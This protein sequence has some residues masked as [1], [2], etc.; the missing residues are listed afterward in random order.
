MKNTL[1]ASLAIL[2]FSLCAQQKYLAFTAKVY[3]LDKVNIAEVPLADLLNDAE[4]LYEPSIVAHIGEEVSVEIDSE[5]EL[6]RMEV[7]SD[8]ETLTYT[9][10]FSTKEQQD[11]GWLTMSYASPAKKIGS[12]SLIKSSLWQHHL[13][14]HVESKLLNRPT[15][16][17]NES[18]N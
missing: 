15:F 4:L 2:S 1:L 7:N 8:K 11:G 16:Q 14:I 17:N 13:I 6:M 12:P 3:Q 9:V 5:S 18:P 10:N